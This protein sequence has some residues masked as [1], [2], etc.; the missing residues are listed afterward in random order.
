MP[1]NKSI[2]VRL[3][4]DVFE[5]LAKELLLISYMDPLIILLE[6]EE[7]NENRINEISFE[8]FFFKMQ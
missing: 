8:E 6:W 5:P 2:E 3:D 4:P 1:L 7:E